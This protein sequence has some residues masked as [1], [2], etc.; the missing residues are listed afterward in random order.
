MPEIMISQRIVEAADRAVPRHWEGDLILGLGNSAIGTLVERTTR[1]TVLLLF[2]GSRGMVKLR[3]RRT[4]PH[5]EDA[6][7]AVR[8]AITRPSSLCPKSYAVR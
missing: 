3:A 1:F 5:S 4:A 7:E 2:P 8:D 6:V